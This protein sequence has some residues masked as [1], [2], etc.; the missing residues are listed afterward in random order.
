MAD[1]V[2]DF[3]VSITRPSFRALLITC[4]LRQ[5]EIDVYAEALP[6]S[7]DADWSIVL[8]GTLYWTRPATTALTEPEKQALR[9]V[10]AKRAETEGLRI[11]WD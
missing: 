11:R 1:V 9:A 10:L 7:T 5:Q 8:N 4:T 6:D 3:T 2:G